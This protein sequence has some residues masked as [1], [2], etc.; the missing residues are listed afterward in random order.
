M[1]KSAGQGDRDPYWCRLWHS[2]LGL[3]ERILAD[4][5]LVRDARVCE[6]G[7]GLGLPGMAA[8][9]AGASHDGYSRK[10]VTREADAWRAKLH[11]LNEIT[12]MDG[13]ESEPAAPMRCDSS[14]QSMQAQVRSR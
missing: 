10:Q 8:C 1:P 9:L 12:D 11:L 7:A 5:G 2:A 6:V 4:P 13:E 3:A 14:P